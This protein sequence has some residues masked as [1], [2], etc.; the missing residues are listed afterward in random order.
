MYR[1]ILHLF[2]IFALVITVFGAAVPREPEAI[3][4]DTQ[5]L[6]KRGQVSGT[7]SGDS[8]YTLI[9]QSSNN[10]IAYINNV[11]ST[12]SDIL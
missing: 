6:E 8:Q 4:E 1:S 2:F 9:L 5:D 10:S 7:H 11:S 3:E 12:Y